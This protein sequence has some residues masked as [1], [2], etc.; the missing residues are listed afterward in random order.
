M[1]TSEISASGKSISA[2][3]DGGVI[4]YQ[5]DAS[6]I[7]LNAN[8]SS[9]FANMTA[10]ESLDIKNWNPSSV[11]TMANMFHGALS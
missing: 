10:L 6:E 3:Y 2:W 11:V 1:T 9:M 8:S 7:Y 4:Y 5:T